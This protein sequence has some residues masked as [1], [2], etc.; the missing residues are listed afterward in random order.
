MDTLY[1][2]GLAVDLILPNEVPLVAVD[3]G[4]ALEC[5]DGRTGKLQNRK[6]YGYRV[7]GGSDFL[8]MTQ[9]GGDFVG[10]NAGAKATID[11]GLRP[12]THNNCG[13]FGLWESGKLESV[14]FP[15][16]INDEMLRKYNLTK[17]DFVRLWTKRYNGKH[18]DLKSLGQHE[19]KEL[20]INPFIGFTIRPNPEEFVY[21]H[22]I[23]K[24]LNIPPQIAVSVLIE[25]AHEL[26]SHIQ[27][28]QL[29]KAA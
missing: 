7:P 14:P 10:F 5:I 25:V 21:D 18:F 6:K 13:A 29:L 16:E 17:G 20:I 1:N 28:V 9:Y 27:R 11:A 19:E 4:S 12:G 15:L 26:A 23:S 8:Q 2:A 22:A 3:P 24:L